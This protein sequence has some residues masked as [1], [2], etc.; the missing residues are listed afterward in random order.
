MFAVRPEIIKQEVP[1]PVDLL[2]LLVDE[3]TEPDDAH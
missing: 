3:P 2:E 1:Q